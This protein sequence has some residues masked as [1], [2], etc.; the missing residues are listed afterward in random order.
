MLS[1]VDQIISDETI[2][3]GTMKKKLSTSLRN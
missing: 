3:A 2:I 1:E